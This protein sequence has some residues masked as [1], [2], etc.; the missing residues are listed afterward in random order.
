[1]YA[2]DAGYR[3]VS[4]ASGRENTRT[5]AHANTAKARKKKNATSAWGLVAA[6]DPSVVNFSCYHGE[7]NF[8]HIT[9]PEQ[10][11]GDEHNFAKSAFQRVAA[12]VRNGDIETPEELALFLETEANEYDRRAEYLRGMT[13]YFHPNAAI[14][15][16][17]EAMALR[18]M[19]ARLREIE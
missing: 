19:L 8:D 3:S 18:T 9:L 14:A 2:A 15:T 10:L 4:I 5:A 1:M 12:V 7:M 16:G 6:T 17:F 11:P 13:K